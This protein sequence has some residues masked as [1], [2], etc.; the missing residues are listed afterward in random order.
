M[1]KRIFL[2]IIILCLI[3][4]FIY[5]K[6]DNDN[7]DINKVLEEDAYSYLPDS[8]KEYIKEY[9]LETG[10][11]I[12]TEKNKK[13]GVA[14]LNPQYVNYL[15]LSTDLKKE[16]DYVPSEVIIDYESGMY[17]GSSDYSS[18]YDLRD[19][20]FVTPVDDQESS[21]LCWAYSSSGQVE[22]LLLKNSNTP[23]SSSS[24]V[25]SERQID[26]AT[27]YNGIIDNKSLY[28][29]SYFSRELYDGGGLYNTAWDIYV[30]SLSLVDISWQN[31]RKYYTEQMEASQVFNFKNSLYDVDSTVLLSTLN[32]KD[33][34]LTSESD[35]LKK[36]EYINSIKN[37]VKNYGGAVVGTIGPTANC[38]I[39]VGNTRLIA[40]DNDVC[41]ITGGHAMQIIGWDDDYEYEYCKLNKTILESS[42]D[43]S[44]GTKVKGKGVWILKNSW[45][46]SNQ[47]PLL[48]YDSDDIS[49]TAVTK[50]SSKSWD[51]FYH[52][53]SRGT[54]T[55]EFGTSEKIDKIKLFIS[56]YQIKSGNLDVYISLD[57]KTSIL[58]DTIETTYPG[59]YTIDLS[60]EDYT[61]DK[62]V[63][64]Y[65]KYGN[66]YVTFTSSGNA[67]VYTTNIDNKPFISTEDYVYDGGFTNGDKFIIRLNQYTRGIEED[68]LVTYKILDSNNNEININYVIENNMVYANNIYPKITIDEVLDKG[69]YT[70][71]TLYNN[72]VLSTSK[73][74]INKEATLISGS[75]T[76]SDPYVITNS[77]QLNLIRLNTNKYY[78][79]GNDIDLSYD[80][81]NEGGLF[82]NDGLGWEPIEFNDTENDKKLSIHF[83]GK[84]YK[85]KG[86][87]INRPN[88][89]Y[90][91]LF[92]NLYSYGEENSESVSITNLVIEDANITGSDYVGALAGMID[93]RSNIYSVDLKNIYTIGGS[94]SGNNYVGGIIGIFRGGVYDEYQYNRINSLFNSASVSAND[95]AGGL[96]GH[97]ENTHSSSN[98]MVV[99]LKNIMNI[100]N[101]TS[102][103]N[104]SGLFG[105]LKLRNGS[106]TIIENALNMGILTGQNTYG[107]TGSLLSDSEGTLSLKN[108]YYIDDVGYDVTDSKISSENVS[109]INIEDLSNTDKYTNW[110]LFSTYFKIN[111]VNNVARIPLLSNINLN[112]ITTSSNSLNVD[113]LDTLDI[114]NIF[115]SQYNIS[116][117]IL[118]ESIAGIKDNLI[119]GK[120]SG[121]TYLVVHTKY[122]NLFI[123]L[124]VNEVEGTITF[125][126]NN[127][128]GST[129]KDT[130]K[131]GENYKLPGNTFSK[132]GYYFL[133]WNTK[134]DG[135]G[136]NYLPNK[137]IYV[138]KSITLYAIWKSIDDTYSVIYN[139]IEDNLYIIK[140]Y[141][142][143]NSYNVE[144]YTWNI[145]KGYKF[146]SW[147]T[148]DD[149]S[150]VDY[151]STFSNIT[152]KD[153]SVINLYG[154]I[155]PIQYKIVFNSNNGYYKTIEQTFTY[156]KK[157]KILKNTFTNLGYIFKEWNTDMY[158]NGVSYNNLE[159]VYNLTSEDGKVINLYAIWDVIFKKY[160][161]YNI[162]YTNNI[163][164][165]I[166]INT[167]KDVFLTHLVLSDGYRID[168]E[169]KEINDNKV[170]FTGGIT[171]VY[172]GD[173]LI[174]EFYNSVNGDTNG[175]GK[176]NSSDLLRIRQHLLKINILKD[177]YF[178]SSDVNKDSVINS[179]DLLR[180]RQHLLNISYIE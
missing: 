125:D 30:D 150:G 148:K 69:E 146:S 126:S 53:N 45:G 171:K 120:K 29:T 180:V 179:S 72:E 78:V 160:D 111:T 48:A 123:P 91:G 14:Y 161:Y 74:T 61:F 77:T 95:Y 97:V 70:I 81:E 135:S 100:G 59:Y 162:D 132:D 41:T 115:T 40:F 26:Y 159:E 76:E 15:E 101:V 116:Y 143:D 37:L 12:L 27:S 60:S 139:D 36:E 86:L 23:Y 63:Y 90:V 42:Y 8:A 176:I 107:I 80:T 163:I 96:F 138:D 175:D 44:N 178:V 119:S 121:N 21:G 114:S 122:E 71:E 140:T 103:N 155:K 58:I 24:K 50:V 17:T 10:D 113:V 147:N 152:N 33:L 167:L 87:Y 4:G 38:T 112:Y 133:A 64:I 65:A 94:I 172:K 47:Y 9:Y 32:I 34:D 157:D 51:N 88:E 35:V 52:A 124:A 83:D 67:R 73:L 92:K 28:E 56:P 156:D 43:C 55:K 168:S 174:M 22:S 104:A 68:S 169:Y 39:D 66:T 137:D 151:T 79:L 130:V 131:F 134:S 145:D 98:W 57:N 75:G 170:M 108:I 13:E 129:T 177:V 62:S 106:P 109:K 11:I 19:D 144:D 85:I 7:V 154:I 46:D 105:S 31:N 164:S 25:F 2:F 142:Y 5:I 110:D 18:K 82:Y 1:K 166:R 102:K 3:S 153:K 6:L 54:I 127:G 128:S 16:Y 99:V 93:G 158:G 89:N 118:D 84:G 136:E 20:S 141:N 117:S 173:T 165:N 49:V 149:G